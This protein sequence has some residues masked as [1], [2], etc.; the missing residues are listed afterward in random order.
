MLIIKDSSQ[1]EDYIIL[2]IALE[3]VYD[4]RLYLQIVIV[5]QIIN[6]QRCKLIE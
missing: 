6:V 5:N 3:R 2:S 1:T 4:W